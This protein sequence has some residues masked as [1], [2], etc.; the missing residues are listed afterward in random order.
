M[1]FWIVAT[2]CENTQLKLAKEAPLYLEKLSV[3]R[4]ANNL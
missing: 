3:E 4:G 1:K 2:A